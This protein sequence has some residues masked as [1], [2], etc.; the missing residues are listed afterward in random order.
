MSTNRLLSIIL[1]STLVNFYLLV[2]LYGELLLNKAAIYGVKKV[3]SFW[4]GISQINK[5]TC[6]VFK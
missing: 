6:L 1:Y 3:K 2:I 4:S 5:N